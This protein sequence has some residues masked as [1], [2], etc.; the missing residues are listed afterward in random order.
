MPSIPGLPPLFLATVALLCAD[1]VSGGPAAPRAP[2]AAPSELAAGL[3]ALEAEPAYE[4]IASSPLPA[5]HRVVSHY[6]YRNSRRTGERTFHAGIDFVADRGTPVYA[7][8][9]GVV[10][11]VARNTTQTLFAGYGNAVVV[12]H[13][14]DGRWS[15]Y[16]HLDDV[17]VEEGQ[18][19]E[20]GALLGHV[21]NTTNGRFPGM[22]SH[23]HFEVRVPRPDGSSP[24]PGVYRRHNVDPAP[25]LA[26]MGV[27]LEHDEDGDCAMHG[28]G[29]LDEH[30]PVLTVRPV[31]SAPVAVASSDA[32]GTF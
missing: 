14:E 16:A 18:A 17:V 27:R 4:V 30:A 1:P 22:G 20:P 11:A 26:A 8:R 13:P 10:E 32:I 12:H 7:V 25:W 21:G 23:L 5:G 9:A 24:F 15:F 29:E 6:G 2:D 28:H 31:E 3:E 19:V